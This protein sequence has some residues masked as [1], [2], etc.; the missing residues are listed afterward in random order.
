MMEYLEIAGRC[1]LA[2]VFI[3]S[4]Y[5]KL[6]SR[7]AFTAFLAGLRDMRVSPSAFVHAVAWAAVAA[8]TTIP[9][10]LAIPAT[11]MAGLLLAMVVLTAFT[12]AILVVLN[13]GVQTSCPCFGSSPVRF[14]RRH[15]VRNG[16]LL[17]VGATTI[18]AMAGSASQV[19]VGG[20]VVAIAAGMVFAI[21][22]AS[23]DELTDLVAGFPARDQR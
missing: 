8:E 4:A 22:I 21:V 10:L 2:L 14:G 16:T 18:M 12:I 19:D 13:R 7:L 1:T 3:V 15:V 17:V 11:A 20:A 6:R 9:I 23:F 5:G